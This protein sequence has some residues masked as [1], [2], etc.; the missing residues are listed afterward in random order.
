MF[1]C[2]YLFQFVCAAVQPK[3][4]LC[5]FA[6]VHMCV[7]LCVQAYLQY[8]SCIVCVRVCVCVCVCVCV[9]PIRH[10]MTG[11][12]VK[13]LAGLFMDQQLWEEISKYQLDTHTHTHTHTN[14]QSHKA[15]VIL[16][17]QCMKLILVAQ[18]AGC[19]LSVHHVLTQLSS[20]CVKFTYFFRFAHFESFDK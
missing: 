5:G 4:C 11:H 10:S 6:C 17:A 8:S 9:L 2:I 18:T 19:C 3:Q 13:Q 16:N 7:L 20:S 12:V 14:T 1:M 15:A